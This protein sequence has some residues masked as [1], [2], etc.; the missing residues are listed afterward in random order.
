[1]VIL[2]GGVIEGIP[3]LVQIVKDAVPT[4]ALGAAVEKLRIVKAGL[5]ADA[6]AIGAAVL[7]QELVQASQ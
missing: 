4:M 2:G 7:A 6:G 1:M 3:E 5:G